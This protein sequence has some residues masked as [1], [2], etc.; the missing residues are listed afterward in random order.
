[1]LALGKDFTQCVNRV[2]L[3]LL[4]A[5]SIPSFDSCNYNFNLIM[6][7]CPHPKAEFRGGKPNFFL[8]LVWEKGWETLFPVQSR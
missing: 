5:R 2:P 4:M 7:F 6:G 3:G 1:M 8:A